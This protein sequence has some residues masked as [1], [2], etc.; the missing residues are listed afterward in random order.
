MIYL[1]D[2]AVLNIIYTKLFDTLIHILFYYPH[3][4]HKYPLLDHIFLLDT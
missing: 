3:N 1:H 4:N 2:M